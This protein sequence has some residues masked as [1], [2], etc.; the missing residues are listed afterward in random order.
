M[1]S[2]N[3]EVVVVTV[4]RRMV[5][6]SSHHGQTVITSPVVDF[7]EETMVAK[8]RSGSIYQVALVDGVD[9]LELLEKLRNDETTVS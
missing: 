1:V 5:G 9:K 4:D 2:S 6:Y 3:I 8:T 7:D